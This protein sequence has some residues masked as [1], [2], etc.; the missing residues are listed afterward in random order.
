MKREVIMS[1]LLAAEKEGYAVPHFNFASFFEL[2]SIMEAA[3]ELNA[4]VFVASL[5]KVT[6][7][8]R[9]LV[10][11]TAVNELRKQTGALAFLHLDH[12]NSIRLCKE[13]VDAGYDSVMIDMSRFPLD[14]NIAAVSE[15]AEYAHAHD[16]AVEGEVGKIKGRGDEG[17][18]QGED[19]L[20]QT[21]DAAL[22]A[23]RSGVDY[24]AAAI[25]TA[26]GF[27]KGEPKIDF[28]RLREVK[29]NVEVPL[30][31]HGG[32]GIPEKDVRRCIQ[33]GI[34]K[35]NVGTIIRYTYLNRVGE[36]IRKQGALTPPV[37]LIYPSV[38]DSVKEVVKKWIKVCMAEG[39]AI[40]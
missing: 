23:K 36:E 17:D 10:L 7:T 5:P 25:G 31:L 8:Y 22:A 9:P 13:A 39:R 32:T 27:Y 14:E 26:H 18:Y 40:C 15:V 30:V 11:R 21:E 12:T 3:A 29:A 6:E 35:V 20:V 4:P 24:L 38:T 16:C 28:E 33:D 1:N 34:S 19:C 2:L 37:D